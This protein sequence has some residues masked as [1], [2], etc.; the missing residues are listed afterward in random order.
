MQHV[1]QALKKYNYPKWALK[2]GHRPANP[3]PVRRTRENQ[4]KPS[5]RA[6]LTF[7]MFKAGLEINI[8]TLAKC[9]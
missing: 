5:L 4:G 6:T 7:H 3:N 2:K 1:S 9:E 8:R